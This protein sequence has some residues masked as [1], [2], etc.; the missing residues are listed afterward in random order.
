MLSFYRFL[1]SEFKVTAVAFKEA[2]AVTDP[3]SQKALPVL[4]A[5]NSLPA[6]H[7]NSAVLPALPSHSHF[8]YE[9]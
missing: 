9:T 8:L 3:V 2:F 6:R 5:A 4:T 7:P 1:H